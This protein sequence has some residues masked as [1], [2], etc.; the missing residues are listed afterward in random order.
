[1]LGKKSLVG[2][3]NWDR[4]VA[5]ESQAVPVYTS[6]ETKHST[7]MVGFVVVQS[8]GVCHFW[9]LDLWYFSVFRCFLAGATKDVFA[10]V[11]DLSLHQY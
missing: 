6:L 5:A 2:E 7:L 8:W 11:G 4:V 10:V 3:F 9:N 1:M